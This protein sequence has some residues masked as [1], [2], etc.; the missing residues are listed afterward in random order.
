MT[1]AEDDADT[2]QADV[3]ADLSTAA[4]QVIND[5]D[6]FGFVVLKAGT[7]ITIKPL[8]LRSRRIDT[9]ELKQGGRFREIRNEGG[10]QEDI[11]VS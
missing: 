5:D 6:E 2:T 9:F 7:S 3:Y 1:H 10:N 11:V 8:S 4:R